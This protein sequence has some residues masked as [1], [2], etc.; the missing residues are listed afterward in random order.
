VARSKQRR[1]D[2][3]T[4]TSDYGFDDVFVGVCKGVVAR[5][6]PDV[7][8]ID[9]CHLVTAHDVGQGATRLAA[10][11]PYLPV[12]VNLALVDPMS[13]V[14]ARGV[15][16]ETNDDSLFVGPDNGLLSLAWDHRGGV[17]RAV[18]VADSS[19][20]LAT[21]HKTFR[22]R[23]VFAP[24]AAHLAAGRVLE[25]VGPRVDAETLVRINMREV[26]NHD[27][28]VHAEVRVVDH[29]GNVSLNANRADLEAAGIRFGDTVELR[30]GGRTVAV[31]FTPTYGDVPRGRLTLCEDSFRAIMLSVNAGDA[32]KELRVRRGEAVVISRVP[33]PVGRTAG[34]S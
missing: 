24:V 5:I 13:G 8:I 22:G 30:C 6:A 4:F 14:S 25:D 21:V 1:Y 11:A 23:D 19:L 3:V 28:H 10:A 16:V 12:A 31:P 26:V 33:Q 17:R 15:V 20:W 34:V 7:S 32:S 2:W 18:E 29:F 9:V 27:D